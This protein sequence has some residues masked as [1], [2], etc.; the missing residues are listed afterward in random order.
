VVSV[1]RPPSDPPA[2]RSVAFGG[3]QDAPSEPVFLPAPTLPK[4]GGAVRGIGEKAGVNSARGTCTVGVPIATTAGRLGFG[5]SLLLRYDSGSGNSPYGLG[6]SLDVSAIS[7]KTEKG[8][9]RYTDEDTFLISG[10][11]DLVPIP[12]EPEYQTVIDGVAHRVQ[13]FRPRTE[14][15]FARIERC[16]DLTNGS[17]WWRTTSGENVTTWYGRTAQ[18]RVAD[19]GDPT[20]VFQWLIEQAR[21]DRGNVVAY[22]YKPEDLVGVDLADVAEANRVDG[23]SPVVNRY[24][25][26]IR[27]GNRTPYSDSGGWH[28]H[29]VIDYDDHDPLE[30]TPAEARPWPVRAD[31]YSSYRAGF[32]IRTRRLARRVLM[33]H[34][35]PS[36]ELGPGPTPR[37]VRSTDLVHDPD[38]V[39][40]RLVAVTQVGYRWDGSSAGYQGDALP[41]VEFEYTRSRPDDQVRRVDPESAQNLP[42]GLDEALYQFVDLDGEGLSGALT[43]QGGAWYYKRNLGGG[44][45]GALE[46][47]PSQPSAGT[48]GPA[49]LVDLAADGR[50]ALVHHGPL[51]HGYQEREPGGGWAPFISFASVPAVDWDDRRVRQADLDGDGLADLLIAEGEV[52]VWHRSLGRSGYGAQQRAGPYADEERGPVLLNSDATG[53]VLLADMSGDGLADLVR[54]RNGDVCYWPNLGHGWFGAKVTMSDPPVF[55]HPD[56]FEP[57]RLRPADVDGSGPTDLVYLGRDAVRY[58]PN[59]SGNSFGP[60]QAVTAFPDVDALASVHV[61]D[62]LG[63]GTSCLV[64]SSPLAK[65]RSLC[66]VDLSRGVNAWLPAD[67]AS[68]RGHKPHLLC[69]VRNNFGGETRLRYAPS[70]TFYLADRAAGTPWVT[71]LPF[72]VHVVDRVETY[73]H[74]ARTRLVTTYSYR[75]GY[76][77]GAEREFR[78]FGLVEQVDAETFP[79]ERGAGLFATADATE[80][81][82]PPV[83]T[84]TWWH[85]GAFLDA[86]TIATQFAAE[87]YAGDAVAVGMPD[88][89]VPAGL[90]PREAREARRALAGRPLRTEV[91]ADDATPAAEHPYVVTEHRYRVVKVAPATPDRPGVYRTHPLESVTYQYERN[92]ADP[93]VTHEVTVE[94]D[95]YN[96]VVQA[97]SIAY[98][99]RVPAEPEQTR[100]AVLWTVQQVTHTTGGAD[101]PYRLATPVQTRTYEVSGLADPAN[102]RHTHA[103]LT[104]AL[105]QLAAAADAGAPGWEVAPGE[106]PGPVGHPQRRLIEHTRA[107]YWNDALDGALPL[108]QVGARA[109]SYEEYRLA[110]TPGLVGQVY[111]DP[112]DAALLAEGGH[113]PWDGGWWIRSG[114][115]HYDP[116]G[117]YLPTRVVSPFGNVSSVDYDP[118]HLLVVSARA[119]HTAPFDGLTT[120]FA[121]DY[122]LLAP[123]EVTDANGNRTRVA[124]DALG[125]VVAT[126]VLGKV[127]SSDGD[128]PDRPGTVITYDAW[129]WYVSKG[130][131]WAHVDTRERHGDPAGPWQRARAWTDGSGRVAMTKAQAE[132]GLAWALDGGQP[133]EVDTSP[134]VRWVGT[135]RTVFD[136]KGRPVKRYEPYFSASLE[137]EDEAGLVGA[138]VT[139]V[140]HY[141]PLGRLVRTEHPDGTLSRVEFDPWRI[142]TWDAS[143]TVLESRWYVDRGSPDPAAEPEPGQPSRRA[144]WLAVGHA[145][146]PAVTH[147]D[148][149]GRAFLS[150]VD[151]GPAGTFATRTELDIEGNARAVTDARGVVVHRQ[152]LDL[153][154]RVLHTAG[155]DGGQR[156]TVPD[157]AGASVRARDSRGQVFRT[158]YDLLRRPVGTWVTR[159]GVTGEL[160]AELTVYGESLSA[161]LTHNLRGRAYLSFDGAGLVVAMRYDF[162]GNLLVSRRLLAREYHEEPN[163]AA[164][165]GLGPADAEQAAGPHLVTGEPYTAATEFDALN[166][167]IHTVLPDTTVLLPRYNAAGRLETVSARLPGDANETPFVTALDYDAKG[168][169]QRIDYGNGA[170]TLYE[171]DPLTCRLTRLVTVR[172]SEAQP[173]RVQDL[174]YTHDPVGNIVEI[175]DDAQP[176]V[177]F[178]GQVVAPATRYAYDPLYRLVSATGREHASL[179]GPSD[180]R[181]PDLRPLPHPHDAQALRSYAQA[182]TYDGVGNILALSHQ[183]DGSGWTREYSYGPDANRLLAHSLP[184]DPAGV[185]SAAFTHD[186]HG[187]MLSMPHL[188][189]LGWDHADRLST[190]DLGGGGTAYYSYDASGQRAR[191]VIERLG[192]LTEERVYLGGYEIHRRRMNGTVSFE[193]TTVHVTDAARR[194]ALIERTT[195]DQ[196]APANPTEARVRYQFDNHLGSCALELDGQAAVVW[197]EEYHPFGTTSLWLARPGTEVS[198]RRY[199]YTGKEKD[200]ETALYYHG[201]RY[202]APWLGRWIATD[203]LEGDRGTPYSYVANNPVYFTDPDGAEEKPFWKKGLDVLRGVQ[204]ADLEFKK[205]S[206]V[207]ML[208]GM[209]GYNATQMAGAILERYRVRSALPGTSKPAALVESVVEVVDPLGSE[210]D[211]RADRAAEQDDW[212]EY[213]KQ[214]FRQ[215][216]SL[217][218]ALLGLRGVAKQLPG[219]GITKPPAKPSLAPSPKAPPPKP[220]P[221][222]PAPRAAPAP[223]APPPPPPP[224]PPPVRPTGPPAIPAEPM[225]PVQPSKGPP[226]QPGPRAKE[227]G[228]EASSW[229]EYQAG[230][231]RLLGATEE[232]PYSPAGG[233]PGR[234]MDLQLNVGPG[235]TAG[236]VKYTPDWDRSLYNPKLTFP[237]ALGTQMD[238]YGQAA[239]Y[240]QTFGRTLYVFNTAEM[241]EAYSLMFSKSGFNNFGYMHVPVRPPRSPK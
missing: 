135:G 239:D 150:V 218:T 73:D 81:H 87:Y 78:G 91:Y 183:A 22:A 10:A 207:S 103:E 157:V 31:A 172:G 124:F 132:P 121:H 220:A 36:S 139:P 25:K 34:D 160:L 17:L 173:E 99:R 158:V 118:Y 95:E 171:Y 82:R 18:A 130:P 96:T 44:R 166:R 176:T 8:L 143:D 21:D 228:V 105:A 108:G 77:D 67:D 238:A 80:L 46:R 224:P 195:V 154:G 184:G 162:K 43:Q 85:T 51:L 161:G 59:R 210:A 200:E 93:R 196:G 219:G 9:P 41:P 186:P 55:D 102:G 35:F 204:E 119:S 231:A 182:Y 1:G 187:N 74:V 11:E 107:A 79:G 131:A 39:A 2:D 174:S 5:P 156:W 116:A 123:R 214:R 185:F 122:R 113:V 83:R 42:I 216:V 152:E 100:P 33:F 206:A 54:V 192:G 215:G 88:S 208:P 189:A 169:R 23:R 66:Y 241:L 109:L 29:V 151:A 45:L 58:W 72:P 75:H 225:K 76:Y 61:V 128:P 52:F 60:A 168:Q 98:P 133:V 50:R 193:R 53:A 180:H 114:V 163:W 177:F 217:G 4:G 167:P 155:P 227:Y 175:R 125:R 181:E 129:S 134:D 48:A 47:L 97:C 14:G 145:Q 209:S 240:S 213:G 197:Y 146:T 70:T 57:G 190:V 84:R 191:K 30:P 64:W 127:G 170:R 69:A 179:G 232:V 12:T 234:R 201:A 28:F 203:P 199:R 147:L 3:S 211:R 236:E 7:R 230:I 101:G 237:K 148:P 110:L 140:L 106:E 62:L 117:Y 24:L 136:N 144:A 153:A 194:I 6:W 32:E 112:I 126:W 56:L 235:T 221:P 178:A 19:P 164:L 142:Q 159:P 38:P 20:R 188:A 71:R 212:K 92:P 138:G 49:H 13:R 165:A 15:A 26:H 40:T 229:S 120:D 115:R 198:D 94:V 16:C 233:G 86:H 65:D 223:A 149:L 205:E 37:L 202:Y 89:E 63:T 111:G 222:A 27:Y 137:Y 68:R 104:G 226:T 141:D 90:T